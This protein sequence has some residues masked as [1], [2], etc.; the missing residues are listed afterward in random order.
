MSTFTASQGRLGLDRLLAH[1]PMFDVL[2][3]AWMPGEGSPWL[4]VDLGQPSAGEVEAWAV[5]RF[6][7]WKR[8]GAVHTLDRE[9]A[10]SDGPIIEP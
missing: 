9:G 1:Y 2:R 3:V 10:V 8:T 4:L 6:A 7:I 5:H